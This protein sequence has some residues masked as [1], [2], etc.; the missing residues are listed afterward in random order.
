[1]K[2]WALVLIFV[3]VAFA[4]P[5]GE[6][7]KRHLG[8]FDKKHHHHHK[9][10][11][12]CSHGPKLSATPHHNT[13]YGIPTDT[14]SYTPKPT[15]TPS[16]TTPPPTTTPSG[17]GGGD[18][19]SQSDIQAYLDPQNA[20]RAKHGANPLKWSS[21]LASVAETWAKR[22]V[23]EHSKGSLGNYGENLSAGS[24]DF[25]IAAAIKLW[26]DEESQYD[27]ANPQYS[28][29]TQVVWKST[30]DVGCA[31][32]SCNLSNFPQEYWPI[33]FY[34]CEYSPPGN[35]IGEFAQNVG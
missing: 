17:N 15:T 2:L 27:P 23:F 30:T 22:C 28:H 31:V 8:R 3:E 20:I 7:Y 1:M 10:I 18:S 12:E 25:S 4:L 9:N 35:V 26:T 19:T 6:V 16:S 21:T 29:Y 11:S 13:S 24:G 14:P 5:P 33:K 34:V 32:A